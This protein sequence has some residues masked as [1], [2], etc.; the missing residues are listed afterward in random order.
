MY[1]QLIVQSS[2]MD[3]ESTTFL[4]RIVLTLSPILITTLVQSKI[5]TRRV[6][7]HVLSLRTLSNYNGIFHLLFGIYLKWLIGLKGSIT[8][9]MFYLAPPAVAAVSVTTE[10]F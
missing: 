6:Q 4:S 8:G 3:S 10:L 1:S 2:I 7:T 5:L 9:L